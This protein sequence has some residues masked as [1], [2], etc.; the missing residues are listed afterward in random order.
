ML[1][2]I[3]VYVMD[4]FKYLGP[5]TPTAIITSNLS[6]LQNEIDRESLLRV[7]NNQMPYFDAI[8]EE[9]DHSIISKRKSS[10]K[11]RR[12]RFILSRRN[13]IKCSLPTHRISFNIY[14]YITLNN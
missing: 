10:L 8:T 13:E 14:V 3:N 12:G 9:D 6:P 1:V 2:N 11:S 5:T 4:F 7:Q